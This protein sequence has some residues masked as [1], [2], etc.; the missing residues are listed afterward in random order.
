MDIEKE[1]LML[2]CEIEDL[3]EFKNNIKLTIYVT[4]VAFAIFSS[5]IIF[6]YAL[7]M[8]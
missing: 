4:I 1:I 2:K 8:T 6:G 7:V 5:G 3:N